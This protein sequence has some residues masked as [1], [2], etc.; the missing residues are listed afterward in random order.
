VSLA[1]DVRELQRL[2][3]SLR[4]AG[5]RQYKT[6]LR[7]VHDALTKS[8]RFRA[9]FEVLAAE[10]AGF[11]VDD[12][13]QKRVLEAR[14]T[15]HEWPEQENQKL[16]VLR[17][18]LGEGRR[19]GQVRRRGPAGEGAG[20][21]TVGTAHQCPHTRR[22]SSSGATGSFGCTQP[23]SIGLSSN[24]REEVTSWAQRPALDQEYDFV[25]LDASGRRVVAREEPACSVVQ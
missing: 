13:I 21:A 19:R 14:Q 25:V 10:T 22:I 6:Q 15:C 24:D 8:S 1:I 16:R 3:D 7:Y 5:N 23:S 12:W 18:L 20:S 11:E 17:R 9:V 2:L 4:H